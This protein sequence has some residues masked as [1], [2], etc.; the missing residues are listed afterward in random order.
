MKIQF[1][2]LILLTSQAFARSVEKYV[3]KGMG[4]V[5]PVTQP[6][7]DAIYDSAK[8]TKSQNLAAQ[9]KAQIISSALN[10][11]GQALISKCCGSKC[12]SRCPVGIALVVMGGLA[13]MQAGSHGSTARHFLSTC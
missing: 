6:K 11:S 2:V 13:S 7:A 10:A 9:I 5:N 4:A 3:P 1:L 8:K 12:S